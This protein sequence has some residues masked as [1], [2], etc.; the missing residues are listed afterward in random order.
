MDDDEDG[1][2]QGARKGRRE[3]LERRAGPLG[4]PAEDDGA[5]GRR[6]SRGSPPQNPSVASITIASLSSASGSTASTSSCRIAWAG[7]LGLRASVGSCASDTPPALLIAI[8]PR[9]P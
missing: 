2:A 6:Q 5:S 9:T 7:I 1:G 8:R 4:S 3:L